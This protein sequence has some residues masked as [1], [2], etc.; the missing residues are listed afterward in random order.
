M[1]PEHGFEG[2]ILGLAIGDALGYPTEF[3]SLDEI[4]D[5]YGPFGVTDFEPSGFHPPGTYTD[6]TQM[7]I[8]VAKALIEAGDKPIDE[9]MPVMGRHFAEW[10]ESPEN[11]RAPG[12]T[13]MTAC[14]KLV[15]GVGWRDSGVAGSKGCGSAMRAAPI[16]LYYHQGLDRVVEMAAASSVVTHGHPTAVAAAAGTA[17][18]VAL[19]LN[20]TQPADL[21]DRLLEQTGHLDGDYATKIGQVRDTPGMDPDEAMAMLGEAWVGEEALADALYCFLRSPDD[22][23]QTVLTGANTAGDSDSIACIAGAFSGA[24]NGIDAIPQAWRH[25]VEDSELLHDLAGALWRK[26]WQS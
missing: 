10:S 7:S 22:Y 9:L 25:G 2:C 1:G 3:L 13:C 20:E 8:A 14:R 26:R 15:V 5:Q 21:L 6:D 4:R 17:V 18:A 12:V 23:G 16:G 24:Y 11:N 19:L